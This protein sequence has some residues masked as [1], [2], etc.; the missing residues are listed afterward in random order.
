[1][2]KPIRGRQLSKRDL[3]D[4]E[5]FRTHFAKIEIESRLEFLLN[6]ANSL[7]ELLLKAKEVNLTID[8]KKKCNFYPRRRYSKD[9][10]RS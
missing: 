7:E 6:R 10:F 1:M 9:K 4:E 5:F 3:Y 8:L 2:K